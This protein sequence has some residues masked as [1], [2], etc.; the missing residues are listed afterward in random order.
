MRIAKPEDYLIYYQWRVK[1]GVADWG[2]V[3]WQEIWGGKKGWRHIKSRNVGI[4]QRD[5]PRMVYDIPSSSHRELNYPI[6][7]KRGTLP[8]GTAALLMPNLS[9]I[10]GFSGLY[11]PE[12]IYR[13][14]YNFL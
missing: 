14:I 1:N 8:D 11:P 4:V 5:E 6:L 12:R 7:W 13:D 3:V 2:H 10:S 9:K